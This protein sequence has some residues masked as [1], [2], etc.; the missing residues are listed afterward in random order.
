VIDLAEPDSP[1]HL[2]PS[3]R[4]TRHGRSIS[5]PFPSLF[6]SGKRS[7]KRGGTNG[8]DVRV[9]IIDDESEN[10]PQLPR[11][12]S[13]K[14]A[15][16]S[17]DQNMV[18][19]RCATCDSLVRWPRHLEVYRCTACLMINDL[20]SSGEPGVASNGKLAPRSDAWTDMR[21]PR[22]GMEHI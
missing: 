19:G 2:S 8:V 4:Q 3:K 10:E 6:G 12:S 17:M 16:A 14:E 9:D 18:S 11:T 5:H 22:K 21:I 7:N 1:P 15:A 13:Q 20:R